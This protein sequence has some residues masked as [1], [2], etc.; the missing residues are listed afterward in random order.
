MLDSLFGQSAVATAN[1][2]VEQRSEQQPAS[3]CEEKATVLTTWRTRRRTFISKYIKFIVCPRRR[4][5][6]ELPRSTIFHNLYAIDSLLDDQNKSEVSSSACCLNVQSLRNKVI[7]VAD[8][9][10]S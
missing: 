5:E 9:V 7:P 3:K 2:C 6:M 4:H 1:I 10:L 8:Y